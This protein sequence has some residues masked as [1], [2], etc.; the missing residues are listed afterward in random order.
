M[1]SDGILPRA[2]DAKAAR[3]GSLK[4][5]DAKPLLSVIIPVLQEEK[6]LAKHIMLYTRELR[7][8]YNFELIVS[9]GGS[10]DDT[11][12]IAKRH[13]DKVVVHDRPERQTIA[14]GRNRG[15]EVASG[16]ILVFIN[17]DSIPKD[18]HSFFDYIYNLAM[19]SDEHYAAYACYVSGFPGESLLKDKLFYL[20]H[21]EYVRMLNIIGMG[22]GRGECQIVRQ[23]VFNDVGGYNGSIVAGEDFDLY[24][25]IAKIG[26]IKF[27][28]R[29]HVLE[30]PRR[31]RK[32]GY[33]RTLWYW[34]LNSL[35]VMLFGKS[36]S[37]EWEAVR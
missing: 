36:V 35:T 9:D 8:K 13:A 22:M 27:E 34:T 4:Q 21:N 23:S 19:S 10:S 2:V 14:E 6:L 5:I 32:Y 16:K 37:K 7:E 28:N 30:S 26:K 25:R 18:I 33:I 1:R 11:V 24:R 3:D 17:A 12:A 20:L 15:A 29:L 31:F